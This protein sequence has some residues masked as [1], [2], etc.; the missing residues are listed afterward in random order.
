MWVAGKP[1]KVKVAGD[2]YEARAIGDPV[3]EAPSWP[4]RQ[5][6]SH[7]SLGW[8]VWQES[9]FVDKANDAKPRPKRKRRTRAQ[10]LEARRLELM[11]QNEQL[12]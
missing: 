1:L 10:M 9:R 4:S 3:P 7:K 12:T 5:F 6:E 11:R 8:L 2:R